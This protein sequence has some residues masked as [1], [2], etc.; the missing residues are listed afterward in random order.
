MPSVQKL[1]FAAGLA[2]ALGASGARAAEHPVPQER[3]EEIARDL[4]AAVEQLSAQIEKEPTSVRLYSSRGDAYFF[5]ADFPSAL[6]DYDKMLE[7]QPDLAGVHWRRGLAL[8]YA[9]EFD[10]S[11]EQFERCFQ[12]DQSDREN[13]LWRFL[14]QAKGADLA[15]AREKMLAYTNDDRPPLPS[16]Y[17]MFA[18]EIGT[19]DVLTE[20]ETAKLS[21]AEREHNEFYVY[22]Y[23]GLMHELEGRNDEARDSL[24]KALT[25]RWAMQASYGPRYMW[26]LTR[27][28]Y[29]RLVA[30]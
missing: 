28:H 19:Q 10:K 29:D 20:L 1:L 23:V 13:G 4:A 30:E 24:A 11:A 14:A 9:G 27:V 26:H 2:V 12:V 18:G 3:R 6:A 5:Q 21:P 25:N 17:R 8:Y 7:V 16:I 15:T 22:L